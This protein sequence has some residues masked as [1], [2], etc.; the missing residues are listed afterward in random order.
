MTHLSASRAH[1]SQES[2]AGPQRRRPLHYDH[3]EPRTP[4]GTKMT[5]RATRSPQGDKRGNSAR[6]AGEFREQR[7]DALASRVAQQ[8]ASTQAH[9]DHLSI[10]PAS[11]WWWQCPRGMQRSC[12]TIQRRP[13]PA[14]SAANG[15]HGVGRSATCREAASKISRIVALSSRRYYLRIWAAGAIAKCL[16]RSSH[17]AEDLSISETRF[18]GDRSKCRPVRYPSVYKK[19][20]CPIARPVAGAPGG[21]RPYVR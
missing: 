7:T 3:T 15:R 14:A 13:P 21:G 12:W 19:L 20:Q 1:S 8:P 6:A 16:S 5:T 9:S 2:T 10:S 11:A 17:R 4:N 18:L